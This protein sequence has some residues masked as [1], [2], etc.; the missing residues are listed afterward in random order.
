M[1]TLTIILTMIARNFSSDAAFE[2]AVGLK[3]KTVYDWKR[4]K[5]KSYLK[6]LPELS[7]VF[8]LSTDYLLGNEQKN[9]VSGLTEDETK[10]L[11]YYNRLT[12][13]SKDYIKGEMVRLYKDEIPSKMD[14]EFA[15][16]LAT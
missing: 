4:G 9:V 12:D 5:S 2:A 13:E 1:G 16:E 3:P 15:D 10:V 6:M 7:K 11:K 14:V 8:G